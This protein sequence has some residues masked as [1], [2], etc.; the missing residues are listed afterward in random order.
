[1]RITTLERRIEDILFEI[2]SEKERYEQNIS[3]LENSLQAYQRLMR[4]MCEDIDDDLV[5]VAE[6]ILWIEGA[7]SKGGVERQSVIDDAVYDIVNQNERLRTERFA[8]KNYD[9]WVGQR[10]DARYGYG[11]RHGHIVFSVGLAPSFR[12]RDLTEYE[13][14]AVVYYLRNIEKIEAATVGAD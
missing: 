1:M 3:E 14:D 2:S 11:P 13:Q 4:L 10:S 12:E 9:C 6:R 8:T 7:Y 5:T